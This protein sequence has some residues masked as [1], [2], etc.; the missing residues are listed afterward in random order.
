[1]EIVGAEK[2]I[3][4]FLS[5]PYFYTLQD[6]LPTRKKQLSMWASLTLSEFH[7]KA[8]KESSRSKLESDGFALYNNAAIRRR[9]GK[10]FIALVLQELVQARKIE[11]RDAGKDQFFIFDVSIDE[12]ADSMHKWARSTGSLGKIETFIFLATDED[13]KGNAFWGY[14]EEVLLK[15]AKILEKAG[16][17]EL[18]DMGGKSNPT[19]MGIK[20]K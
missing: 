15:A 11:F 7:K 6:H 4:E 14:P 5:K 18:F 20:F 10:E 13:L 9:L 2:T 12:I 19:E 3:A 17:A 16:K 8:V 1:M